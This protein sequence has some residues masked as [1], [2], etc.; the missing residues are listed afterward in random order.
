M[1]LQCTN[2]MRS[3]AAHAKGCA[4]HGLLARAVRSL[5]SHMGGISAA[6]KSAAE[7]QTYAETEEIVVCVDDKS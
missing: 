5:H 7:G 1:H 6:C 2:L 3:N 4:D